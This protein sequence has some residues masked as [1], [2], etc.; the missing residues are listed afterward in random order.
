M[1][2]LVLL[3]L[4]PAVQLDPWPVADI[5]YGDT[6][7]IDCHLDNNWKTS[8]WSSSTTSGYDIS[9][10]PGTCGGA[11]ANK[12]G[13]GWFVVCSENLVTLLDISPSQNESWECLGSYLIG[14]QQVDV[15]N[16]TYV[17]ISPGT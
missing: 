13:D 12:S 9:I 11:S 16:V 7:A 1:I 2:C 17:R 8:A 10:L 5:T 15:S 3:Y 14:G 4:D 6:L